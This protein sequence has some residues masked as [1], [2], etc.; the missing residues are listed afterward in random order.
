MKRNHVFAPALYFLIVLVYMYICFQRGTVPGQI[1]NELSADFSLTAS[2]LA[3]IGTLFMLVYAFSQIPCG[4]L[5]QKYGGIRVMLASNVILIAGGLMFPFAHSYAMLIMSRILIGL[6]CSFVYPCMID[7]ANKVHS[8]NFTT[9]VGLS[10]LFGFV[11]SALG[12]VPFVYAVH[13]IGWRMSML[14]PTILALLVAAIMMLLGIKV[15]KT[16]ISS[17]K[18]GLS[19]Y[20]ENI[21]NRNDFLLIVS[22][23]V[24]FGIYYAV[25][26]IFG[27]KFLEDSCRLSA[28]A[29]SLVSMLLMIAPALYNPLS[30]ILTAKL[31]NKRR[32]FIRMMGLTHLAACAIILIGLLVGHF[33]GRGIL[34]SLALV[35]MSLVGGLAPITYAATKEYS[36]ENSL[37]ILTGLINFSA[38]GMVFLFG[39]LAGYLMEHIGG[40]KLDDG[41][42]LYSNWAYVAIFGLFVAIAAITCKMTFMLPETYGRNIL[43]HKNTR[44]HLGITF[45]Y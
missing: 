24:N 23:T 35:M 43:A 12:T 42:I 34:F 4:I 26:A 5:I 16:P 30:G 38:Y 39:T 9:V 37:P 28:P 25:L 13:H 27:K 44:K 15:D 11:A 8:D 31:G 14:L 18:I 20:W 40:Q 41:S 7:E 29:A 33:P 45:H 17:K 22:Y 2:K 32:I 21:T 10:C 36:A 6:G 19:G 1:F 3:S